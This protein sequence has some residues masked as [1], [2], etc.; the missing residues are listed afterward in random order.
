MRTP[1]MQ[2][3][4]LNFQQ[5]LS[6]RTVLQIGYVG[7][8]GHKLARFRD[9]NQPSQAQITAADLGCGCIND[10]DVPRRLTDNFFYINYEESFRQ[11]QLQRACK[12]ACA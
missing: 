1:Y 2:N 4:N 3:F 6:R 10:G 11:F 7:S 12:P 8:N 5:E 9:I